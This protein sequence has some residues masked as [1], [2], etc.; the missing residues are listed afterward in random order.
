MATHAVASS[1]TIRKTLETISAGIDDT[2]KELSEQAAA[3]T[4]EAALSRDEVNR[5]LDAMTAL[6]EEMQRTIEQT[7]LDSDQLA[8]DISAAVMAMQFQDTVNQRINHVVHILEEMHGTLQSQIGHS[9]VAPSLVP[10]ADWA[11][12]MAGR[13]TMASEHKVLAAHVSRPTNDEQDRGNNIE[14]F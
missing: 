1:K 9:G 8:R 5:A 7:K 12:R 11:S 10:T 13:Y 3:D 2:S 6:H 4:R 14:L